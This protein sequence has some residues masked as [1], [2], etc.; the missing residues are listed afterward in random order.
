MNVDEKLV[1]GKVSV[2]GYDS[3]MYLAINAAA[4]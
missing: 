1:Y 4:A 3:A 2:V